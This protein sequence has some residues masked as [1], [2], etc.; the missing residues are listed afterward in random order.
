M[1]KIVLLPLDERPCN[2]RYPKQIFDTANF[3]VVTPGTEI[4]GQKKIPASLEKID[5]FLLEETKNAKGL[6]I[7]MDMLLYGGLVPSRLH[8]IT[9]D[10]LIKRFNVLKVIK[11]NN[12]SI[13]IY[14][15][16]LI[17]RCP[18][19]SSSDEEPDYYQICGL[20]IFRTGFIGHKI[21]LGLA[22][23]QEKETY[24]NIKMNADYLEDYT[25]RRNLNLEMN[26]QTLSFVNQGIID[27]L[28]IPQD[29]AAQYGFTAKNQEVLKQAIDQYGIALKVYMYPGADEVANTLLSRMYTTINDLKPKFYIHYPSPSC[30]TTIPLLEDRFLDVTVRYQIRA[31]GGMIVSSMQEADIILFVNASGTK[32]ASSSSIKASRDEGLRTQRNLVDFVELIADVIQND[33]KVAAIADVANLNG[34]DHE[35]MQLLLQKNLLLKLGAY[36]GW[37]TSSNTL[38]TTIPHSIQTWHRGKTKE[39]LDFLMS[40]YVEDY[41][42]MTYVKGEVNSKLSQ[43]G[44]NYFD[45]SHNLNLIQQMVEDGLHEFIAK[46][47]KSIDQNI[48][49]N[50]VWMP[51]KRMF[52]VGVDVS[53]KR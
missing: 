33:N 6:V 39:H 42:Y 8:H 9:R 34:S 2:L 18:Q 49:I 12:P 24:Q 22:S 47:L 14:A 46:Y 19:Y 26:L 37:N 36:A 38:G 3:K 41:G 43:L 32:M 31:A 45:V 21:E 13:L 11:K 16:D 30:A 23:E 15:F 25:E 7:S 48:A 10:D 35:F 44:M 17:M 5:Q 27:F 50:K 28:I 53:Y 51:W 52:E 40:R 20:E 4:L 1:P 29:D